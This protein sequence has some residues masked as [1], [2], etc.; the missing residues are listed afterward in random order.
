MR[1]LPSWLSQPLAPVLDNEVAP[2]RRLNPAE[3][4][5]DVLAT[6]SAMSAFIAF[7]D[8]SLTY[9]MCPAG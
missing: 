2:E 1:I 7:S 8:G 3:R 5:F 6:K 4:Y 9:I